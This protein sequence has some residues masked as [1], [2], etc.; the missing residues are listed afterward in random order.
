LHQV[1]RPLQAADVVDGIGRNS[2]GGHANL[3]V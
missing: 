1:G 2:R 3:L